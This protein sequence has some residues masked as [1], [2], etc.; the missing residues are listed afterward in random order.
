M[1]LYATNIL[2]FF[3]CAGIDVY[4]RIT[5]EI[6][7]ELFMGLVTLVSSQVHGPSAG[8]VEGSQ[9]WSRIDRGGRY[10]IF[11]CFTFIPAPLI[12]PHLRFPQNIVA[13]FSRT[14]ALHRPMVKRSTVWRILMTRDVANL[15]SDAVSLLKTGTNEI[16]F[17]R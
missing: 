10:F 4:E 6:G 12:K 2:R 7:V 11:S 5:P 14:R 17:S 1:G 15:P 3:L 8:W 16:N 13:M 9:I